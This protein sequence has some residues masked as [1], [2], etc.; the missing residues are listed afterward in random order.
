MDLLLIRRCLRR[1]ERGRLYEAEL[2][3]IDLSLKELDSCKLLV[4][5]GNVTVCSLGT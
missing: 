2:K 4:S 1:G 3:E 5:L